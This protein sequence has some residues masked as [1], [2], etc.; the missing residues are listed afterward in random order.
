MALAPAGLRAPFPYYGGKARLAADIWQRL[1]NPTVYVEPFA[2][3]L[4]CL[5]ARPGGPGPREIVCDLDGGLCNA[6]RALQHAPAEVAY[7]ADYPTIHHDLTARHIWLR[8]WVTDNAAKLSADPHYHDAKAAGWWLW[9]ISLWIGGGWCAP[10]TSDVDFAGTQ[11]PHVPHNTGGQGVSAQR[12]L[13]SAQRPHIADRRGG[14]G[15]S[16]QRPHIDHGTGGRG[17][18]AQREAMP[19]DHA[20]NG[21]GDARPELVGWFAALQERL[22]AVIV[23]NRDWTSA[24]TSTV[25]MQT[26]TSASNVEVGVLLDPPYPTAARDRTLYGS[27][28]TG[29]SHDVAV[30]SYLWAVEHGDRFRIAYCCHD[31]DFDVPPGWS[32]LTA[33]FAGVHNAERRAAQRDLVMFSPSCLTQPTLFDEALS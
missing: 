33:G 20:V 21:F 26:R 2:G 29:D 3:S 17:V 27:D 25:L 24:V 15:V 12:D 10:M 32:T 9:G 8:E 13:P 11:R 4:A 7:W 18:S 23:L 31:G 14:E 22:K 16:A 6:W 19:A 5:L 1:G 30:A 28:F